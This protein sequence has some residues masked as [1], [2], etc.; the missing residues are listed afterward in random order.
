MAETPAVVVDGLTKAYGGDLA[1][2]GLSFGVERGRGLRAPRPQR[3]REDHDRR[4]P[5]GLP[6]PG[7][8]RGRVLGLD[9][10]GD[11]PVP[12]PP[13]R[14]DAA[15]GR[16]LPRAAGGGG[17]RLFSALLRGPID[18][19][20]AGARR[21]GPGSRTVVRR[22]SGGQQ[23]GCRW[24]SRWSAGPRSSSSTSPPP[25]WTLTP[26]DHVGGHPRASPTTAATRDAHHPRHGRGRAA[27]AT[28][29][30]SSTAVAS[31]RW[32]PPAS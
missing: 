12:E 16:V 27:C 31:W 11:G 19:G 23:Q 28:G 4:D 7:R 21:S 3:R 26:S 18:P 17:A 2:D 5:R 1:V 30:P 29:S 8:G 25:G 14:R 20:P 22:L 24:P 15:G 13:H 10:I 6:R 9:P 32:A